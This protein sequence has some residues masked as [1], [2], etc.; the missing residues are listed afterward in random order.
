MP[1]TSTDGAAAPS[2]EDGLASKWL[3]PA[4]AVV[5]DFDLTILAIH[6][7]GA[8][9]EPHEV[10]GRWEREVRDVALLRAFVHVAQRKGIPFGIASYGRSEVIL[11][12]MSAI[13]AGAD[14]PPFTP[15]N[16]VTPAALG[17]TDGTSVTDGKPKMLAPLLPAATSTTTLASRA[18]SGRAPAAATTPSLPT[19]PDG[20]GRP[21]RVTPRPGCRG[22]GTMGTMIRPARW[23]GRGGA[24][25][26]AP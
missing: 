21:R 5:W 7:F 16:V 1:E 19:A 17:L 4:S 22:Q 20:G 26:R 25:W 23:I 18:T 24:R 8:G 13:F 9:V 3:E 11:A 12:Y 15:D 6:A 2:A 14:A 10:P